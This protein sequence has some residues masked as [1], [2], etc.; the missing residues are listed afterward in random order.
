MTSRPDNIQALIT[1]ID[2]IIGRA[3]EQLH[4]APA[5]AVPQELALL[6]QI[7]H[8][9]ETQSN[10]SPNPSPEAVSATVSATLTDALQDTS[11]AVPDP[12][13]NPRS[14]PPR[15]LPPM[16]E[17]AMSQP[18]SPLNPAEMSE[19][20]DAIELENIVRSA[21]SLDPPFSGSADS[22]PTTINSPDN[23]PSPPPAILSAIS[24]PQIWGRVA[25]AL[26]LALHATLWCCIQ[27]YCNPCA[28]I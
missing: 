16:R 8:Y 3:T 2:T 6:Q 9:L 24:P 1:E 12:N 13:H 5:E 19:P 7:R 14:S 18:N 4:G 15:S 17:T 23:S 22:S 27:A 20:I 28:T 26:N 10:P 21:L 25:V 11:R